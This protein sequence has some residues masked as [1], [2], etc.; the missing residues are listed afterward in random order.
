[1]MFSGVGREGVEALGLADAGGKGANLRSLGPT[2]PNN[3]ER[4]C[5]VTMWLLPWVT[6]LA[7]ILPEILKVGISITFSDEFGINY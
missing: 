7:N 6:Y 4:R 2:C 1:M 3:L 5:M